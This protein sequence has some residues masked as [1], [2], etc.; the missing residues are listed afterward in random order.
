M[1]FNP[2]RP[3]IATVTS[4]SLQAKVRQLLPSQD[5]FGADLAAQNVIVPVID[6]TEAAQGSDVPQNLQTALAFGS[7]TAFAANS[8]TVDLANTGGFYRVFGV[9]N[10][11]VVASTVT[12]ELFITDGSTNKQIFIHKIIG[13]ASANIM[14]TVPIDVTVFLNS[15]ETLKAKTDSTQSFVSGSIR[16]I[17]D[18]NGVLVNPSGF[19]PQ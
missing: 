2:A 18:I 16:Q 19:N 3:E 9:S 7:Q 1:V 4:E 6:L 12:N 13:T 11:E 10:G 15:G 8:S 17:A 14:T 5:G